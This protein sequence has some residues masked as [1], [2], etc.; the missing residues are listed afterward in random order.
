MS[1]IHSKTIVNLVHTFEG[2]LTVEHGTRETAAW[3]AQV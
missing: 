2:G 3:K 1:F